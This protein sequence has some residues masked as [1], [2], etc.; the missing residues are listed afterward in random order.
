MPFVKKIEL[1]Q[2]ILGIWELTDSV[3]SLISDFHFS[4]NEKAEFKKFSLKKR[5]S[6]YIAIRLLLQQLMGEKTE[7]IYQESGRPLIKNSSLNVSISHSSDLVVVLLSENSVG[8][9]VENV[10][11]KII[12]VA[13]RFLHNEELAWIEKT[14]NIQNLTILYWGAKESIFK[15]T[16]QSGVQYD[17]Q[18]FIPPF[19]FGKTDFFNGKLITENREELFNLWYFYF[20]NNM[21][22]YCVEV[23]NEI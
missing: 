8:I 7:I 5:Q 22:V 2:G 15:C 19:D 20:K 11:R 14:E 23:K 18:I 21:I 3:E 12:P 1:E 6:E 9:D 13:K 16:C 17:T 10:N 4:E